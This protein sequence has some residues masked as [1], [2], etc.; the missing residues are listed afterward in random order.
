[1]AGIFVS[2]RRRDRPIA[3]RFL[4]ARLNLHYGADQVFHDLADIDI[5]EHFL[6]SIKRALDSCT[7]LIAVIGPDWLS[8]YRERLQRPDD[9]VRL[10]IGT[11][12]SKNVLV[13]PVL[14]G[15]A[16]MPEPQ[17]LPE[18]L[19]GLH[20]KNA[21]P[22]RSSDFDDDI[23]RLIA[24]LDRIPVL[25][26]A[27]ARAAAGS[28]RRPV[29]MGNG[30]DTITESGRT[31]PFPPQP[32]SHTVPH[33]SLVDTNT[34]R[35]IGF[36][37]ASVQLT[38]E[39]LD[40]GDKTLSSSA[41][42]SVEFAGNQWF[43]RNL[44]SNG[45]TFVQITRDYPLEHGDHILFGSAVFRFETQPPLPDD[46]Q[47]A[48]VILEQLFRQQRAAP[49]PGFRLS[50]VDHDAREFEGPEAVINR[51]N[52]AP[53]NASISR[54]QHARFCWRQERWFVAD[55]SSNHATF[56]QARRSMQLDP[57]CTLLL[58]GKLYH[59][60]PSNTAT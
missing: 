18:N 24:R 47:Q 2:Y 4:V 23:R 40:P 14:L 1:M 31:V 54:H 13:L 25:A 6:D 53:G 41:H 49:A 57:G 19:V 29:T 10:E 37:G 15:S 48:T 17:D 28:D 20:Y 46:G 32:G 3:T 26:E 34:E 9:P 52:L 36:R 58:G 50:G 22:L 35:T 45:A 44:S 7:V 11:A 27:A 38:R 43:I 51:N 59:F 42:A 39:L 5:G 8:S 33:F 56:V 16:S 55:L 30:D 21:V 60:N 12:L